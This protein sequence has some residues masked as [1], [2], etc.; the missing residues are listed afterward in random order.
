MLTGHVHS[1]GT[2]SARGNWVIVAN[3]IEGTP[4]YGYATLYMHL[5]YAVSL[6]VGDYVEANW[7]VGVEGSTGQSTGAHL[8]VE[9]QDL[10]RF[11]W[12][13]TYTETKSDYIDP[14]EFMRY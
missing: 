12:T 13:W 4:F 5:R 14:T 2:N 7:Q 10:T 3:D 8:H 1:K 11:N 6:N 9:M